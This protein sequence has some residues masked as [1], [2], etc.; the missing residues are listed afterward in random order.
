MIH[1]YLDD[2]RAC[3][4]GFALARN[5]EECLMML[6]ECEV[7]I[8]SLDYELGYGQMN[9]GDVVAAIV[10]ERLQAKEIYLHTS[11]P[12]GRRKMYEMLYAHM[13]EG[14]KVHNG[15]MPEEVLHQVAAG[16]R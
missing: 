13:P 16:N 9:G 11:S 14:V 15:P 1:L 8:L 3:P 10:A 4:K 7:D 5:G 6:R 12:S 2:W